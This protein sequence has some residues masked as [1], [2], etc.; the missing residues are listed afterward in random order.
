MKKYVKSMKYDRST[1]IDIKNEDST[2]ICRVFNYLEDSDEIGELIDGTLQ[3]HFE[4]KNTDFVYF[5]SIK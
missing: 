4:D 2:L 1:V 5:F 3:K